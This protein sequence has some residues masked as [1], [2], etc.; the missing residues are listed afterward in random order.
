M[1][2]RRSVARPPEKEAIYRSYILDESNRLIGS[3]RLH[4]LILVDED[5]PISDIMDRT[6]ISVTLDTDQEEVA[7]TIARYNLLAIPVV[8]ADGR[9]ADI[10]THD[11]ATD[12]MQAETSEDFQR[13]STVPPFTQS[14][15]AL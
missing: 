9:L 3:I 7:K 1:R 11:D 2:S 6:P 15:L 10:V 13:I 4:E 5:R 14:L 12:A 8:D